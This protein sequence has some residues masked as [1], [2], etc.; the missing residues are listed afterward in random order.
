MDFLGSGKLKTEI[1][2]LRSINKKQEAL[3]NAGNSHITFMENEIKMLKSKILFL[4]GTKD[5]K[6][7][8]VIGLSSDESERI[9]PILLLSKND[10]KIQVAALEE[11]SRAWEKNNYKHIIIF[12]SNR[13][14]RNLLMSAE[15]ARELSPQFAHEEDELLRCWREF[16]MIAS[17]IRTKRQELKMKNR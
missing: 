17:G 12:T 15:L 4:D 3:I 16:K 13:E 1:E 10:E 11:N 5:T 9:R 7:G 8:D 6:K 2:K 14:E